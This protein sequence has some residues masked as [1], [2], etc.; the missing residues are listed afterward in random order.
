MKPLRYDYAT[1]EGYLD[2][3]T[4]G[5]ADRHLDSLSD[6]NFYADRHPNGHLDAH[7][8]GYAAAIGPGAR[9]AWPPHMLSR[10][11]RQPVAH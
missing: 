4:Y 7:T 2:A 9:I 8:Y 11:F 3:H 5:Y 1:R 10:L 6:P